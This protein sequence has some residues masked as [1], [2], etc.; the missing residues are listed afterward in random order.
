[1]IRK[2]AATLVF[3]F[4]IVLQTQQFSFGQRTNAS[5][6]Q[7]LPPVQQVFERLDRNSDN[8]LSREEI[9]E[10]P[11]E[12][13]MRADT[14]GD[15]F[16]SRE[17][18]TIARERFAS[19]AAPTLSGRMRNAWPAGDGNSASSATI[20]L[21]TLGGSGGDYAKD[22]TVDRD[23]NVVV[24]AYFGAT[25]NIPVGAQT[26][27][28]TARG[29]I[30]SFLAKFDPSGNCLWV[31]H[32]S[33][34]GAEMPHTVELDAYG[35]LYVTGYFMGQT[36]FDTTSAASIC[37]STGGRDIFLAKY[38]S[39]GKLT[40]IRTIGSS[41]NDDGM[42]LAVLDDGSV[43]ITAT[44]GGI[45]R[46]DGNSDRR[47]TT[48]YGGRGDDVF[49]GRFSASGDFVWGQVIGGDGVDAGCAIASVSGGGMVVSG[50][51][52]NQLSFGENG[53]TQP[54]SGGSDI[55]VVHLNESGQSVW[56]KSI[57]GTEA[58]FAAPGGIC[59]RPDGNVLVTGRIRGTITGQNISIAS[60]GGDDCF[61]AEF[62]QQG[63][64]VTAYTVGGAGGDG[65][66]R[67]ELDDQGNAVVAGWF[68]GG[69]TVRRA[70][71]SETF[72]SRGQNGV[73]DA[74]VA[75][76]DRQGRNLW[77]TGF[78]GPL[79]ER[80]AKPVPD[81]GVAAG[82]AVTQSGDIL[83]CGRF[84]LEASSYGNIRGQTGTS[85]GASDIFLMRMH[86][87]HR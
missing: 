29:V 21:I 33:G 20:D 79:S 67:I 78:G 28:L 25:I 70:T 49:V 59:V 3:T 38:S 46:I 39:D 62:D 2:N 8:R 69:M 34:P 52:E 26:Q 50:N 53:T 64:P 27:V 37:Y 9:P 7:S 18:L 51:Y 63:K 83:A 4:L 10:G 68:S 22:V 11:R 75:S 36:Q 87:E 23:G 60:A 76:F 30:D 41:G 65:G 80:G 86:S 77:F 85:R 61:V 1:M 55:F 82:L 44:V 32:I 31:T 84:Y 58:D 12:T 48:T 56:M 45:P 42:D 73:P 72:S 16:V 5:Q 40:W 54:S 47:I 19:N 17:E 13:M 24:A 43:G 35:N 71:G 6:V 14:D 81:G 74:F 57:G 15:G 66:H